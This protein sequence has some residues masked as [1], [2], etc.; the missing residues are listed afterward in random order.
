M[1]GTTAQ[2]LAHEVYNALAPRGSERD[3]RVGVASLCLQRETMETTISI[4]N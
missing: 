4:I 1:A 2:E 3:F